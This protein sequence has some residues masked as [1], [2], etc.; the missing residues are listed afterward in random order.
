MVTYSIDSSKCINIDRLCRVT[1]RLH[2]DIL[3]GKS[4]FR[5]CPPRDIKVGYTVI[6]NV[7]CN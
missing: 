1:L 6:Q 7:I 4:E 5:D 3:Q 2:G